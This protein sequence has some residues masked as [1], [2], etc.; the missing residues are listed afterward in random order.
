M[1]LPRQWQDMG[2]PTQIEF[3]STEAENFSPP[4]LQQLSDKLIF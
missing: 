2:W 4:D 3:P 1:K